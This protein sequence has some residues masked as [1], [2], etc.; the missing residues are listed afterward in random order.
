MHELCQRWEKGQANEELI[1]DPGK[2]DKKIT[3]LLNVLLQ[4]WIE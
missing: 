3:R 2:R 1:L 4:P